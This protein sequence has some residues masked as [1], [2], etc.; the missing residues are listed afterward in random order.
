LNAFDYDFKG[1][2]KRHGYTEEEIS[3]FSYHDYKVIESTWKLPEEMMISIS[4]SYPELA[5]EDPSQWTYGDY[6]EYYTKQDQENFVR[7]FTD[8]QLTQLNQRGILV[9]D[10][11]YLLKEFHEID[12]ILAQPDEVLKRTLERYYQ[13][14]IDSF[15]YRFLIALVNRV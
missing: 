5:N 9:E 12:M 1:E 15:I 3:K 14:S 11:F 13:L 7:S 4:K 2:L 10:T 6:R 8:E